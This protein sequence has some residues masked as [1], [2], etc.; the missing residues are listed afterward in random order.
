MRSGGG[1]D[2]H[3][4]TFGYAYLKCLML[5]MFSADTGSRHHGR[6]QHS[7]GRCVGDKLLLVDCNQKDQSSLE[8]LLTPDGC[9]KQV[10]T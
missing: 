4:S 1:G 3:Y 7:G 5:N 6:L 8:Y 2:L 10:K 9:L